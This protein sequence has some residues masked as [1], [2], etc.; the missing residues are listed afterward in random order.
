MKMRE[1]GNTLK[2]NAPGS[3]DVVSCHLSEVGGGE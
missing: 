2:E 1:L 3:D